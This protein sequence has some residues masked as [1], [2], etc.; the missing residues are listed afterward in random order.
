MP[1]PTRILVPLDF[2]ESSTAALERAGE[3]A[4][5][6]SAAVGLMHVFEPLELPDPKDHMGLPGT[7]PES[8]GRISHSAAVRSMDD[9]VADANERGIRVSAT[10]VES[11]DPARAIVDVAEREG[12]DLIVM[13]THG[14]TGF[15]HLLLG[16]VAE[17][18]V[19]AAKC[20]VLT[21]RLKP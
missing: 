17:K 1:G 3:F 8:L 14:R 4:S 12:Y 11:G 7:D 18:V 5:Q 9:A 13:G 10:H 16:S 6:F 2:S 20:P 21:V 19:R 15:D